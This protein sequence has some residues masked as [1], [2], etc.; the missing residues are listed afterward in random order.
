MN[1]S[2]LS[3]ILGK[4]NGIISAY[5]KGAS[6]PPLDVLINISGL[7]KVS[8]DSLINS[9]FSDAKNQNKID[10]EQENSW[11]SR[12]IPYYI[13][14][15]NFNPYTIMSALKDVIEDT[16]PDLVKLDNEI[17]S[18][19][20][21][22]FRLNTIFEKWILY[23]PILEQAIDSMG[24]LKPITENKVFEELKR[25]LEEAQSLIRGREKNIARDLSEINNLL[26]NFLKKNSDL[27]D[28]FKDA[29]L[30]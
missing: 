26:K 22:S 28:V 21:K 3:E 19:N 1:Q 4:K 12:S 20:S 29:L 10:L 9:D 17:S 6:S 16:N 15:D 8:L 27:N 2:D 25:R 14:L 5:E 7:F 18:F 11:N 13:D 24:A 23:T 30:S